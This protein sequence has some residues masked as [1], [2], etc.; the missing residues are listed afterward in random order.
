LPLSWP[1][2]ESTERRKLRVDEML[3]GFDD[4][5]D[6]AL[7]D[8]KDMHMWVDGTKGSQMNKDEIIR[9]LHKMTD[10]VVAHIIEPPDGRRGPTIRELK[11]VFADRVVPLPNIR[12]DLVDA[13][14][15]YLQSPVQPRRR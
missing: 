2:D 10:G 15:Q 4:V 7:K 5:A 3:K 14:I 9:A 8:L 11:T 6:F 12:A 13:C 1:A